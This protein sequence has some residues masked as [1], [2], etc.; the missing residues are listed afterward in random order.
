M[1]P[2]LIAVMLGTVLSP[3]AASLERRG[4]TVLA[5]LAPCWFSLW[6]QRVV[7]SSRGFIQQ[8]PEISKLNAGWSSFW[9]GNSL[10]L[11]TIWLER[12]PSGLVTRLGEGV[13]GR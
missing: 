1:V 11:D 8:V 4:R 9:S 6:W 10:D 13:L 3:I 5:A 2:L 12:E 7:C